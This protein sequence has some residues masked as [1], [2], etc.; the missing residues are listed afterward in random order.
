M[1][2]LVTLV[3]CREPPG[4]PDPASL[5]PAKEPSVTDS[6]ASTGSTDLSRWMTHL[7]QCAPEPAPCRAITEI[8]AALREMSREERFS[9]L[10]RMVS[11]Q[12]RRRQHYALVRLYP[13]RNR[14]DLLPRLEEIV[15]TSNDPG[16]LK[17]ASTLLLLQE[18]GQASVVFV[19]HFGRLNAE[20]KQSMIWALRMNYSHLPL[21][22]LESLK[23]DPVPV[24]RSVALEIQAVYQSDLEALATC[25]RS[26][27]PEAGSCALAI[28]RTSHEQAAFVLQQ[29]VEH[30]EDK[31]RTQKRLTPVPAPLA[32]AIELLHG[33]KRMETEA[34]RDLLW[35]LLSNRRLEDDIRAQAAF[36]LGAV[37]QREALPLLSRY[38]RD[39]RK[40]VGYAAR[41]AM[42]LIEREPE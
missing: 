12:S 23:E 29:L 4:L 8:D 17:L 5:E 34:A 11:S 33:Q 35:R 14:T 37:G 38:R 31:A 41:R 2:W 13:H 28:A 22:F 9:L 27:E 15:S 26:L 36:S 3:A 10:L 6:A 18:S 39:A 24:V 30:F 16:I 42:Y 32:T 40:R 7:D 25:V 20:V 21:E 1:F 19:R